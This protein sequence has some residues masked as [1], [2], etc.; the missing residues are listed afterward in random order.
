MLNVTL[1]RV[2]TNVYSKPKGEWVKPTVIFGGKKKKHMHIGLS[3]PS[4][5]L[6]RAVEIL[7]KQNLVQKNLGANGFT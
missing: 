4:L 5:T 2:H 3:P 7:P 1:V 6:V